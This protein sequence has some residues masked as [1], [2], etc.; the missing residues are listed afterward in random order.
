MRRVHMP[1]CTRLTSAHKL[2]TSADSSPN[3]LIPPAM[4]GRV[5]HTHLT[6]CNIDSRDLWLT[7]HLNATG[8]APRHQTRSGSAR[9]SA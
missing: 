8:E 7:A 6:V 9:A 5:A 4:C 1:L 2:I 3:S